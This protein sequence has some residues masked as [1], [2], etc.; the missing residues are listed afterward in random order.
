MKASIIILT[1][2]AGER[3]NLLLDRIFSQKFYG[4]YEVL[5][6]DS[7]SEDETI[8]IAEKYNTRIF[9]IKPEEF[10]HSKTRNLGAELATGEYL[11]YI[12][13]DALPLNNEWLYYLTKHLKNENVAGVYGRQIAYEDA[14]PMEKF[15][16]SYF[17]PKTM[18]VITC[19]KLKNLAEFYISNVFISDVCSA[20][21]KKVWEKIKFDENIIMA[22]DKKWAIDVLKAG[23]SLVYEP[24]APVY[25]SHN[26]SIISIFKRRFDDGVAMKQIC[27]NAKGGVSIGLSYLRSEMKHLIKNNVVWIPYALFYDFAKFMGLTLGKH[28][29]CIPNTLR[30]RMSKHSDGGRMSIGKVVRWKNALKQEAKFWKNKTIAESINKEIWIKKFNYIDIDID[31]LTNKILEIGCG[32]KGPIHFINCE[33]CLLVGIDPLVSHYKSLGYYR[34]TKRVNHICAVGELLPFKENTFDYVIIFNVLDHVE[35]PKKVLFEAYRILKR[36]GFIIIWCHVL[37]DKFIFLREFLNHVD[38][39]HPHHFTHSE[40]IQMLKDTGFL[41]E[42]EHL[43]DGIELQLRFTDIF[44]L[45]TYKKIIGNKLLNSYYCLARKP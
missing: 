23:Y 22:E 4:N 32:P 20:M 39:S 26:Y 21:K 8:E 34:N 37:Y 17:Y 44:R 43:I 14:K 2:N 41:I 15:F 40:C 10:H 27:G 28:Y 12:T 45:R 13:Q 30:K 19:T 1:K 5:I 42:K 9:R 3:F 16:Y 35:N 31:S 36:R 33:E 18:K 24:N 38:K 29:E 7:G 11:V 6:I 25:H